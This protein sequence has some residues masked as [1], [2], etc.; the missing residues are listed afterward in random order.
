MIHDSELT[1]SLCFCTLPLKGLES[2]QMYYFY[3]FPGSLDP[4]KEINP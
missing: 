4:K 2:V 3:N 1:L